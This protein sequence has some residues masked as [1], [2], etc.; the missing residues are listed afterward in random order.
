ME[1][2]LIAVDLDGTCVRYEPRWEVDPAFI[3]HV[4]AWR[5]RGVRWMMNSDRPP[6][7]MEEI[8]LLLP[9]EAR[10]HAL[11]SRQRDIFFYENGR[12]VSHE[13]WNAEQARLHAG[14]WEELRPRFGEW[15]AE[16]ERRFVLLERYIDEEAFAFMTGMADTPTL[17]ALLEGMLAPW[18]QA[19]V[20][21]NQDWS[22][23]LHAEFSKGRLLREASAQL[24][25][26]AARTVA[27]GDGYNDLPMLD[28]SVTP[29][30][31]CPANACPEVR[32][33]VMAAGGVV[34][35]HP[36]AAGT[37][38]VIRRYLDGGGE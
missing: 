8:A 12:Y 32:A 22:F 30:V 38:A 34:A 24:G 18:P 23:V 37:V 20:S 9:E 26:D 25:V 29:L 3:E 10:P 17:R 11:L 5:E 28:G 21:G 13:T 36:E 35:D 15:A 31:G 7:Q 14:L 4:P 27:V 19:Q 33:A 16:I 1:P 6:F 2:Q